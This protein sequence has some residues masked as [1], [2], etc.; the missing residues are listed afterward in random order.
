MANP[1]AINELKRRPIG[2]ID[3]TLYSGSGPLQNY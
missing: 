1:L 3:S 2:N